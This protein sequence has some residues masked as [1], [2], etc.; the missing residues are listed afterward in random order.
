MKQHIIS[1]DVSSPVSETII[2][3]QYIIV[4]VN[5]KI[6]FYDKYTF[7]IHHT[8]TIDNMK[9]I[10]YIAPT[11]H[12]IIIYANS[13]QCLQFIDC[14]LNTFVQKPIFEQL[15][16]RHPGFIEYDSLINILLISK[17]KMVIA[18]SLI[19][20]IISLETQLKHFMRLCS[21]LLLQEIK[22]LKRIMV[23]WAIIQEEFL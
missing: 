5:N 2:T 17:M 4:L 14:N 9:S 20:L 11:N 22:T 19:L 12:I 1:I 8:I 6:Q 13:K 21:L 18:L 10:M 15:T 23:L 3:N 7:N 16:V